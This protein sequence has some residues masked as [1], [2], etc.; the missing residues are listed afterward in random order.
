MT[1]GTLFPHSWLC[2]LNCKTS[3]E[4]GNGEEGSGWDISLKGLSSSKT[5]RTISG[6][7]LP[8]FSI[9]ETSFPLFGWAPPGLFNDRMVDL[10]IQDSWLG[11]GRSLSEQ[12]NHRD[13]NHLWCG[14]DPARGPLA[15]CLLPRPEPPPPALSAAPCA[16]DLI[17]C[18]ISHH[19]LGP[20][21]RRLQTALKS[22]L[23]NCTWA[24]S[25]QILPVHALLRL[26]KDVGIYSQTPAFISEGGL[27]TAAAVISVQASSA[28]LF[29]VMWGVI[30]ALVVSVVL[31]FYNYLARITF[32]RRPLACRLV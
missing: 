6:K 24:P 1:L 20:A 23:Y 3:V 5:H 12:N 32:H 31:Q 7:T 30:S 15:A 26:A 28:G 25:H 19:A 10:L 9:R 16:R 22:S 17:K 2:F 4:D 27:V 8:P 14:G 13:E 29:F 21:A 11:R 18:Y